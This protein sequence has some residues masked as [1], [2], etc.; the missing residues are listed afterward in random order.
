MD[1]A[2]PRV[3]DH[4]P[5]AAV[6]EAVSIG[7]EPSKT[8]TVTSVFSLAVPSKE[9]V[10]SFERAAGP[11]VIETFGASVSTS[12]STVL[13]SPG[14]L[15]IALSSVARAESLRLPG[16]SGGLSVADH[17]PAEAVVLAWPTSTRPSRTWTVTSVFS[18]AVPENEGVVSLERASGP[19][20]I[21][22][23]GASVSTS[24]VTSLLSPSGPPMPLF[25]VAKA[26]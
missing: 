6:V 8:W 22:T 2:L 23:F 17:L 5:A 18:L 3:A 10:V 24:K 25:S 20:V 1:S 9:G 21:A 4:L 14:S 7:V 19:L 13:L 26:R 15:P 16:S 11:L 12:N